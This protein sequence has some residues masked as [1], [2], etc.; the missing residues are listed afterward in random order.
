MEK[1]LLGIIMVFTFLIWLSLL[2]YGHVMIHDMY[3]TCLHS[4]AKGC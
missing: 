3:L 4:G 1:I 2:I